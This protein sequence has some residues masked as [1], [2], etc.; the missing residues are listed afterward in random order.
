VPIRLCRRCHLRRPDARG[1]DRPLPNSDESL[2]GHG[3]ADSSGRV[4]IAFY[5]NRN[6]LNYTLVMLRQIVFVFA[7]AYGLATLWRFILK[8]PIDLP[9]ER[10][11]A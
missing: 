11:N 8:R 6:D 1:A 10:R 5:I 9:L 2:P 3:S 4:I 7:G